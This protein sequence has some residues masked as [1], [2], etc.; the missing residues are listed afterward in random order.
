MKRIW[1][2]WSF[3]I[4]AI[5]CVSCSDSEDSLP[6]EEEF[7]S[8]VNEFLYQRNNY[9][10]LV[11]NGDEWVETDYD[12]L[13][14]GGSTKIGASSKIW[15]YDG[16]I[17]TYYSSVKISNDDG[18]TERISIYLKSAY[19]YNSK[20]G[21]ISTANE[22]LSGYEHSGDRYFIS[23]VSKTSF[24]LK[25]EFAE[26][27]DDSVDGTI[28]EYLIGVPPSTGEYVAFDSVSEA[29][30]YYDSVAEYNPD[31]IC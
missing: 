20:T 3:M 25:S 16:M 8:I 18:S 1:F 7:A 29:K 6:S 12:D 9:T 5:A 17:Y 13:L 14:D 11:K 26:R 23:N 10:Y 2:I 21:E 27:Y 30:E 22:I 19:T 31:A 4:V 28:A 24:T 15:F